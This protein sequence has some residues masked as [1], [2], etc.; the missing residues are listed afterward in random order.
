MR[1]EK[2][3]R[4]EG[5]SYWKYAYGLV[6]V[7]LQNIDEDETFTQID[8]Y[9]KDVSS[10]CDKEGKSKYPKLCTLANCVLTL[11]HGNA[12]PERVFSIT[13]CQ[14]DLHGD[15]TDECILE[16]LRMVKDYLMRNGGVEIFNVTPELIKKCENVKIRFV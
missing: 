14:L 16:S 12:D 8:H 9:W 7:E 5:H 10:M 3:R 6:D 2:E 11:S 1:E 15:T 4:T 13:K